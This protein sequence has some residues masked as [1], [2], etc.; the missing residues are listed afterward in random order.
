MTEKPWQLALFLTFSISFVCTDVHAETTS[1][2]PEVVVLGTLHG[3]HGETSGYDFDALRNAILTLEPDVL[4]MEIDSE[5]LATRSGFGSKIEYPRVV[6]PLVD[7]KGYDTCTL[8]PEPEVARPIIARY[9]AVSARLAEQDP[10]AVEAFSQYSDGMYQGLKA[11]WT[12]PAT[13]NS[14]LTDEILRAKH[15]LQIALYGKDEAD[16]WNAWNRHFMDRI[17]QVARANHGKRIVALVGVEHGYW[18]RQELARIEAIDLLDTA[19][20]LDKSVK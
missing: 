15:G 18:L 14:V 10:A 2:T 19:T 6:M 7:E 13:V 8:E 5:D 11:Y 20:L 12:S 16:L 1:R 3:M 9:R 4:C 17:L